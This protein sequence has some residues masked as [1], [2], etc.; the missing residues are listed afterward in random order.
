MKL[1]IICTLFLFYSCSPTVQQTTIKSQKTI[2]DQY[3]VTKEKLRIKDLD[4]VIIL[5]DENPKS[6]K[7]FYD[8]FTSS[9]LVGEID[10][11]INFYYSME[12]L[13]LEKINDTV[14]IGPT[15]SEDLILL[16]NI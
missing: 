8:E 6:K 4:R 7:I 13:P 14:I 2:G 12:E 5:L 10:R 16:K 11:E 3:V 1:F 15:T 9:D